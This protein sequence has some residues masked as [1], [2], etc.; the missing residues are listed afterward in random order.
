M[1]DNLPPCG[2]DEIIYQVFNFDNLKRYIEYIDGNSVKAFSQI[3][4]IKMK[5]LEIDEI[6]TNLNE[7]NTRLDN[8]TNKFNDVEN[9]LS[10]QQMKI[11]DVERKAQSHDE[12]I[13]V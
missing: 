1:K 9:S 5:L 12:V 7:I 2:V 10:F 4:E 13:F 6:K 8:F 3:N 11:M